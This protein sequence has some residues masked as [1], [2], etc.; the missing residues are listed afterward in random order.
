MSHCYYYQYIRVE[1]DFKQ[2]QLK[3]RVVFSSN[4]YIWI[5]FHFQISTDKQNKSAN[6]LDMGVRHVRERSIA[7]I[8]PSNHFIIELTAKTQLHV[9]ISFIINAMP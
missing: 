4:I 7:K 1:I 2:L 9:F 6:E 8:D 5:R 3:P